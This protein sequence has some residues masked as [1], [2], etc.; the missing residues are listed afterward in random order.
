MHFISVRE[1]PT[2]SVNKYHSSFLDSEFLC[3]LLVCKCFILNWIWKI[4]FKSRC[5][6]FWI[7][8]NYK[9]RVTKINVGM[10]FI[11]SSND[12]LWANLAPLH[13]CLDFELDTISQTPHQFKIK[14]RLER[15]S[16][17]AKFS[18]HYHETS[19]TQSRKWS[20]TTRGENMFCIYITYVFGQ[21]VFLTKTG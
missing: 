6:R 9:K 8:W 17:N 10:C 5:V 12:P 3:K 18:G 4:F 1:I 16:I 13:F 14:I 20:Q 2:N 7:F 11:Q 21:H 15:W 19:S